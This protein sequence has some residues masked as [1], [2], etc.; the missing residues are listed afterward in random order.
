MPDDLRDPKPEKIRCDACPVMCFIADGKSGA[1]DR[2][3]NHAGELVRLD[4]LTVIQS[5]AKA[6]AFLDQGDNAQDWD[7]DVIQG[8]RDF[9]TAV[10]AGTTY[11]DYKPA[12][13]IVSQEVEGVDMITVVTEGIFSYCGVKVKIDTDR[14]IGDERAVVRAGGEAI[15]HVMTSEYGSKML[16]LGG[17]EH[18]TGGSK[19]EGRVTCDAL[20]R[21][22]NREPV[23]VT[24]DGGVTMVVE[25][26][27]API[28]NGTPEKLMRVGCGSATIGMFAKQWYG[29]VD[30][31]VVVDDHITGV[32]TEHEAGKGLDMTPSGIRVNGRRSTPGR[33]FQVADPGTGWGGTDV[34]D[35][36]TILR[37]ADPKRAWPGLRLL[38][39][40]TTGEQWA[41]FTLD[42][43]LIPQPAEITPELLVVADRIA[44]NCEPSLCSV[45]FM[46]GAGGSLRAG[47]TENPVRLT[48]SVKESLTHVSCGGAE[49]YVWPGGGITVMVDVMDMPTNSFGYVPTPAL[50]APIEFTLRREDYGTL[51]GHMEHIQPVRDVVTDD[52]RRVAQQLLQPDPNARENYGWSKDET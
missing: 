25:A 43:D 26:G 15:G 42:D 51:G 5:G 39:I 2:Y 48:R 38:M 24:I 50:V 47:V 35:P 8:G 13:F 29:H 41:Y 52:V 12:P 6:V 4:P 1:C 45:L 27:K 16:S 10:G 31:V 7:G 17:V 40:S 44:E 20:L 32:L 46:G 18:L 49:A 34:E 33:Y 14:H 3:A 9:V 21:L 30:E 36:L 19:K 23:E 28:I 22:C 37:D 11:P